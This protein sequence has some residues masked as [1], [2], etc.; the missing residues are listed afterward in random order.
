MGLLCLVGVLDPRVHHLASFALLPRPH[1]EEGGPCFIH[2]SYTYL[3][4]RYPQELLGL[5]QRTNRP[6][7]SHTSMSMLWLGRERVTDLGMRG[8]GSHSR[9][10]KTASGA[11]R[12][13]SRL[14][15]P[16][17]PPLRRSPA[18][19]VTIGLWDAP[20]GRGGSVSSEHPHLARKMRSGNAGCKGGRMEGGRNA[21]GEGC[22]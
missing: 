3:R 2:F 18:S 21:G 9:P 7:D 14:L 13:C 10:P 4:A 17:H 6:S 19:S 15:T 8:S 11:G 20:S 5:P 22:R 12:A 1:Q 16:R